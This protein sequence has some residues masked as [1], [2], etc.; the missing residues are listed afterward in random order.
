V[1]RDQHH[2]VH[3]MQA[4][5]LTF[6]LLQLLEQ[7]PMTVAAA[8]QALSAELHNLNSETLLQHAL[9]SLQAMAA[10]GIIIPS[11]D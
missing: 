6:R 5:P 3:F 1:Y 4:V 7:Q 2:D 11:L 8:M 10:K 9:T